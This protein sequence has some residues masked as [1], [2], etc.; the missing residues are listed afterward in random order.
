MTVLDADGNEKGSNDTMDE[1]DKLEVV[2]ANGL[3]TVTYS[4]TVVIVTKVEDSI[5]RTLNVYPNPSAGNVNVDGLNPGDR[6]QVYNIL[7]VLV[8]DEVVKDVHHEFTIGTRERGLYLMVVSAK[9][10]V[11]GHFRLIV[12]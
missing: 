4:I 12:E 11:L 1:G 9:E 5:K 2:S 7:G 6:V 3:N 10:S 8:L